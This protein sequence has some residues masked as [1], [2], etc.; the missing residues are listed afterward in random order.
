MARSQTTG[1]TAL[2]LWVSWTLSFSRSLCFL[3][4]AAAAFKCK[5]MG[6]FCNHG[7]C[8]LHGFNG[9]RYVFFK[10]GKAQ[11]WQFFDCG[12]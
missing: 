12:P 8:V 7:P 11:V 2:C 3:A 5:S 4:A 1:V 10:R 9:P 6:F